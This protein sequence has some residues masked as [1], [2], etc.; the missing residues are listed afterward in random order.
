MRGWLR[1]GSFRGA[2]I[3]VHWS[4]PLGAIFA[5]RFSWAPVF[6]AAFVMLILVHELGH[7]AMVR[8]Y[9][10]R[11]IGVR[12]HG[13]GGECEWSGEPSPI[14]RSLIAWGGVFGQLVVFALSLVWFTVRP[15]LDLNAWQLREA[16]VWSNLWLMAF[17]LLPIAPLD[18]KEAWQ[19]PGLLLRRRRAQRRLPAPRRASPPAPR[20]VRGNGVPG[21]EDMPLSEDA[22]QVI[23]RAKEIARRESTDARKG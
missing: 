8:L 20:L 6:W 2:P 15:P 3:H 1:V 21:E 9:G 22:L 19:L 23:E 14:Q 10:V 11:V 16:F 5:S 17:N 4:L 7:A 13:L 12:L 18:G